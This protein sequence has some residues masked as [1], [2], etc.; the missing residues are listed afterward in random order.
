MDSSNTTS[1]FFLSRHLGW[2]NKGNNWKFLP[3][4][5][6]AS[7][8][9]LTPL[10]NKGKF[11]FPEGIYVA[12]SSEFN[13]GNLLITKGLPTMGLCHHPGTFQALSFP[14][15]SV[16][17]PW[18]HVACSSLNMKSDKETNVIRCLQWMRFICNLTAPQA[19][20]ILS[21][22]EVVP[23]ETLGPH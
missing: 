2:S 20:S 3:I 8:H 19:S 9:I 4:Q 18:L 16:Y 17:N 5:S 7:L 14:A 10:A 1:I 13:A 22:L 11:F 15:R 12:F 21:W 6:L 23:V